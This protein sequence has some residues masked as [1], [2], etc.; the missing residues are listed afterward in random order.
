MPKKENA[1]ARRAKLVA[2]KDFTRSLFV[3]L[4]SA[5]GASALAVWFDGR[6]T[7]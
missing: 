2:I 5:I 4:L 6:W 1:R 3:A 7:R